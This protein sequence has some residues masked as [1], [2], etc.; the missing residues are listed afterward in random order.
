M[1]TPQAP[2][3]LGLYCGGESMEKVET[4]LK[5][6]QAHGFRKVQTA[7]HWTGYGADEFDQLA[8]LLLKYELSCPSFGVYSNLL[9][10]EEPM[11]EFFATLGSDLETAIRNVSKIGAKTVVSW[12]GSQGDFIEPDPRNQT[13]E[14]RAQLAHNLEPL[15]PLL[16]ENHVRLLFEPWREHVLA[17]ETETA[18]LCAKHPE[19]LGAVLDPPNFIA[20]HDWAKRSERVAT[21]TETLRPHTGLVHLKDMSVTAEGG[22]ELPMFGGGDLCKELAH[23]FR[24]F[25]NQAKQVPLVAEHVGSP[26]ELPKLLASVQQAWGE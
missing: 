26:E 14:S 7:F 8:T 21:I 22:F 15:L 10:P 23:A 3:W 18:A 17:N 5:A 20:P 12:A 2:E 24:P 1:T 11:A 13:P 25:T 19:A 4:W 16:K 6:A 9:K